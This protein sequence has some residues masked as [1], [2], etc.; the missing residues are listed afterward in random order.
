MN[1]IK[2]ACGALILKL[3]PQR[4]GNSAL[5]KI[6]V[7]TAKIIITAILT[8]RILNLRPVCL[9]SDAQQ[10]EN[11]LQRQYRF[12][13]HVICRLM[14]GPSTDRGANNNG[15]ANAAGGFRRLHRWLP[16]SCAAAA[17]Y[18][19]SDDCT[20]TA[21]LPVELCEHVRQGHCNHP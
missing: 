11:G 4:F 2:S 12:D 16:D 14:Y 19:S 5:Q 8:Q 1:T 7:A 6:G 18:G 21:P 17:A 9:A 20:Y 15:R 10:W 13:N 3:R